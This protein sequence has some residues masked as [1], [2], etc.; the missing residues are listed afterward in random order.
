MLQ[1]NAL[2]QNVPY[3]TFLTDEIT[4]V[5]SIAEHVQQYPTENMIFLE[6]HKLNITRIAVKHFIYLY[7]K[8]H[9][10]LDRA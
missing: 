10:Y 5:P 9:R 1:Q 7:I 3:A 2:Q 4:V 8:T 6:V